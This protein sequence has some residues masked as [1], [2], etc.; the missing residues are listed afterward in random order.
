MSAG[1]KRY[2][3][4]GTGSR[5]GMYVRALSNTHADVGELVAWCDVNPVRMSHYAK[6]V[7]DAG[8]AEV[9][10]YAA[11]DFA[12]MLAEQRPDAVII[13]S[14]D[15]THAHYICAALDAGVDA[16]SE[17][18]MTIDV[19]S[20]QAI[21]DAVRRSKARLVVT[22]NY[23]YSPRNSIIREL[24]ADGEIG[25]ITSVHFE[26]LLDTA[27]GADYF[28]RWHREKNKSGGLLVHKSTHHFDLVNWWL[29][30][31]PRTVFALGGLRFYG[32]ANATARGLSP[33]PELSRDTDPAADPFHLELADDPQLRALYLDAENVDGYHRDQDVFAPGITIEDTLNLAVGYAGGAA[34]SYAL[35][36]YSPWE[37]Y[38]VGFNGTEG[39]IELEVIERNAVE[40]ASARVGKDDAQAVVDPSAQVDDAA[41]Q[42]SDL[43]PHGARVLLQKQWQRAVEVAIPEGGGSHGGGDQMLLDDLFRG[44]GSD[45]LGRQSGYLDGIR[46]AVVGIAGNESLRTGAAVTVADFGLPLT[47]AS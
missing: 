40:P 13:T 10:A 42:N 23:R 41:N 2:A 14:P 24:I 1:R 31:V 5:A 39:R 25:D 47:D 18:P 30:D 27:H 45:P 35:T 7:A 15:Y 28:R 8:G 17:K 21:V 12:T 20:L 38:R 3:I 34:M 22:F 11:E 43:R 19:A 37:G 4:V 16:I 26:W 46:S 6:L 36:A 44:A 32:D 29:G 9:A 33:R